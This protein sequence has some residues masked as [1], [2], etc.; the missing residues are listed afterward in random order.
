MSD[1]DLAINDHYTTL[2]TKQ[3]EIE[4]DITLKQKEA[5][6]N[7]RKGTYELD[8]SQKLGYIAY[9][10]GIFYYILFA[11]CFVFFIYNKEYLKIFNCILYIFLLFLP[12]LLYS[13]IVPILITIVDFIGTKIIPKNVYYDL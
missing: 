5:K 9:Y 4:D 11:I 1:Y 8:E 10:I 6:K 12:Y 13:Y 2:E 7:D 3:T